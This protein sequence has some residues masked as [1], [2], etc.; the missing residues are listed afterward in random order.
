MSSPPLRTYYHIL[1]N[2]PRT[3]GGTTRWCFRIDRGA[4]ASVGIAR[5]D[6]DISTYINETKSGWGWYQGNGHVGHGGP[7]TQAYGEAFKQERVEVTVEL[8][9]DAG[10]VCFYREG[11][12]QGV[13]FADLPTEG[14]RYVCGI[15]LYAEGDIARLVSICSDDVNMPVI[16]A[17]PLIAPGAMRALAAQHRA[18]ASALPPPPRRFPRAKWRSPVP[19]SP[20]CA[21][22][23][24]EKFELNAWFASLRVGRAASAALLSKMIES[25]FDAPASLATLSYDDLTRMGVQCEHIR[26]LRPGIEQLRRELDECERARAES[27]SSSGTASGT[28]PTVPTAKRR[29]PEAPTKWQRGD[30]HAPEGALPAAAGCGVALVAAAPAAGKAKDAVDVQAG[31]AVCAVAKGGACARQGTSQLQL[32]PLSGECFAVEIDLEGTVDALKRQIR[33]QRGAEFTKETLILV[34]SGLRLDDASVLS[35]CAIQRGATL[36]LILRPLVATVAS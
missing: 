15:T 36:Q 28:A 16:F 29:L 7:A 23:S 2:Q 10:T 33:A 34:H 27:A 32:Q 18:A 17:C 21:P 5:E 30:A 6:V 4:K 25:G 8:N 24:L 26:L 14:A 31:I 13:A 3:R 12:S 9:A 11:V 20:R 19:A 35:A 1:S 22:L